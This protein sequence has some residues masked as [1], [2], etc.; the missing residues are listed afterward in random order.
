MGM[1]GMAQGSEFDGYAKFGRFFEILAKQPNEAILDPQDPQNRTRDHNS[2]PK[3]PKISSYGTF[4]SH[5][6]R[7]S[8]QIQPNPIRPTWEEPGHGFWHILAFFQL[9]TLDFEG[10][11]KAVE[12][13]FLDS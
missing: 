4:S 10:S 12:L 1:F 7:I 5:F 3:G 11:K 6:V 8:S 2:I 13:L 9:G